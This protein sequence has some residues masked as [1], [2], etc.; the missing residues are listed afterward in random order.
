[1]GITR[2]T[3]RRTNVTAP[4]DITLHPGITAAVRGELVVIR[5]NE[6]SVVLKFSEASALHGWLDR[7]LNEQKP[8]IICDKRLG[9][10]SESD[11]MQCA[12]KL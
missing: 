10:H 12:E 7:V 1:V 6:D 2:T 8:C 5:D 4:A 9:D 3:D 11:R